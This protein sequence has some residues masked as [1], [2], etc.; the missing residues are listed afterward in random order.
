MPST[1]HGQEMERVL[2]SQPWSLL[3]LGTV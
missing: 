3:G 2:F 1:T